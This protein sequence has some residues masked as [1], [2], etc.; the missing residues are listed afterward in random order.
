MKEKQ[1]AFNFGKDPG[2]SRRTLAPQ[3]DERA[4]L[5]TSQACEVVLKRTL[6][7]RTSGVGNHGR[8]AEMQKGESD[9]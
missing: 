1:L 8:P 4:G 7:N 5:L 6:S 3:R 9:E 2:E